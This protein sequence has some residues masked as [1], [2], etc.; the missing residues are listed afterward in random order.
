MIQGQY[1]RPPCCR[2]SCWPFLT[3]CRALKGCMSCR[4]ITNPGCTQSIPTLQKWRYHPNSRM[5]RFSAISSE[6]SFTA[7]S[8]FPSLFHRCHGS[9]WHQ[10]VSKKSLRFLCFFFVGESQ[11]GAVCHHPNVWRETTHTP[12]KS[13]RF[14]K[15]LL[16]LCEKCRSLRL[17]CKGWWQAESFCVGRFHVQA[18]NGVCLCLFWV[19]N[20]TP[21]TQFHQIVALNE[22]QHCGGVT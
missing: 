8:T 5:N 12:I 3:R 20:T 6:I 2:R 11:Q 13:A 10:T 16:Q 17:S 4:Y 9:S 14:L 15:V 21:L 18:A 1:H 7:M 19:P 22:S